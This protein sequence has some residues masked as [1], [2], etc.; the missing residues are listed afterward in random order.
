MSRK[1]KLFEEFPPVSTREWMDKITSDLKGADF[2]KKLVW[3]TSEGFDVMPFYRQE[4]IENLKYIDSLPGEFPYLRGRRTENNAWKIRQNINV[5]DFGTANRKALDVLMKGIDSPGFYIADPETIT[6]ENIALLLKD[7]CPDAV[8]LNFLTDGKAKELTGFLLEYIDRTNADIQKISGAVEADPLSRLML[9]GTLCITVEKGLD[10]L[11]DVARMISQLPRFRAIHLNA[12]NFGNAGADIVHELAFGL[13]MGAEYVAQ[14][15]DR[16]IKPGDAASKIRFSFGTGSS[17]F[18]EIAKLRAAR[19]LWSA[20]MNSFLPGIAEQA[21]MEI[22]CVTGRWNKTVYDPYVNILRTQTEA[23]SAILG[24]TDSLTVEP[25][26]IV[27]RQPDEFSERIARNQQLILREE[28]YFDK[29]ADPAAG[30]YY[31]EN[32]TALIAG[33]AWKLFLEVEDNG[34][35]LEALK[36]GFIQG[37]IR[38]SASGR[39]AD[40][41]KRKITLLGTNMYPVQDE[42]L[43]KGAV[44]E[45]LLSKADSPKDVI[46]E[47]IML[48]RAPEIFEKLRMSVLKAGRKPVVFLLSTGNHVMRKA[49]AQFSL[50]FFGCAGYHIIDNSGFETDEEGVASVLESGADIT[51]ICSSDEEYETIVPGIYNQLKGKT[52]LVVAGNPPCINDLKSLGIEYFISVRSDIIET[53]GIFNKLLGIES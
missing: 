8:E 9:N 10:Y 24:G 27:F 15:S 16:E 26:D 23:M 1:E 17:Y 47:P 18:Q 25:F 28:S 44:Q 13:A 39:L 6:R 22:H 51:V 32:L 3:K 5:T 11:A 30:S 42:S 35:F 49:R 14:L 29:V 31:V 2:N 45:K 19:L 50:N 52:I 33:N 40:V 7:I 21:K 34:G 48:F 4:D 36:K 53:I 12:S 38:E 43:P 46:V 41:A 20:I 37:K